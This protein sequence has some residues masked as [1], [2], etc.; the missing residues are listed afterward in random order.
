M[1]KSYILVFLLIA[2]DLFASTPLCKIYLPYLAE[3]KERN[4]TQNERRD[5]GNGFE[6]W[7]VDGKRGGYEEGYKIAKFSYNDSFHKL[8]GG[9]T[10][11]QLA[12]ARRQQG[13][14]T[15]TLDVF[16]SAVFT[17]RPELFDSLVGLRFKG[18]DPS[19]LPPEYSG[20]VKKNVEVT[21]DIIKKVTWKALDEHVGEKKFDIVIIRPEG[22]LDDL[23][24]WVNHY[25][26]NNLESRAKRRATALGL[27]FTVIQRTWGRVSSDG[28]VMLVQL[29]RNTIE[30]K[31]FA[32][33]LTVLKKEGIEFQYEPTAH[34]LPGHTVP[35]IR[36]VK[37]KPG[38][39]PDLAR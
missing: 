38:P 24:K 16:G 5:R 8:M 30:S 37:T 17:K 27:A 3:I 12:E 28:G 6:A 9:K 18:L 2:A 19:E 25:S 4:K 26:N 11:E 20:A 14:T 7:G 32:E 33:W 36:L 15:H 13:K 35:A 34:G 31:E 22:V 21:G 1:Y 23:D 39:L 10:L 29:G